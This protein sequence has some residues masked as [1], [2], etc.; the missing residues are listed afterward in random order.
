MAES[1]QVLSQGLHDNAGGLV[2][3][4]RDG[5]LQLLNVHR[6][7]LLEELRVLWLANGD[8]HVSEC[9]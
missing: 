8:K 2:I 9:L 5:F 7:G 6:E 1:L 3:M 4:A